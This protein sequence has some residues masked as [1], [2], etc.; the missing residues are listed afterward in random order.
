VSAAKD[1]QQ[2]QLA[3]YL[4]SNHFIRHGFLLINGRFQGGLL[5]AGRRA[6]AAQKG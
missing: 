1:V 3:M 5:S 4:P 6:K 2:L